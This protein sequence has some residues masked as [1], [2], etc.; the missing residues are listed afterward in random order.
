MSKYR[1]WDETKS[2]QWKYLFQKESLNRRKTRKDLDRERKLKQEEG[3][4]VGRKTVSRKKAVTEKK[5]NRKKSGRKR[6][7]IRPRGSNG[8]ME[9]ITS[10]NEIVKEEIKKL[11]N[12]ENNN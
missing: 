10:I 3:D 9:E 11:T 2:P 7:W 1:D 4:G 12:E 5:E 8:R 6:K